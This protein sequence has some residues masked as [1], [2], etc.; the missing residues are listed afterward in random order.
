MTKA[1]LRRLR[2]VSDLNAEVFARGVVRYRGWIAIV[3]ALAAMV[4]VPLAGHLE[5]LLEVTAKFDQSESA[6]VTQTL[7][8]RFGSPFAHTAVLVASEIPDPRTP[9]GASVLG[10]IVKTVAQVPG[11][12]GTVS[13]LD[14]R[15]SFFVADDG[16][17]TFIVAGFDSGEESVGTVILRLR[18]ATLA[19]A[20]DLHNEYPGAQLNWSGEAALN[21]DIRSAS[22]AEAQAAELRALPLTLGVLVLA[23]GTLAAAGIP[24]ISGVLAIPLALGMAALMAGHWSMSALLVNVVTMIGLA[25]SIDY[26]LLTVSRFREGLADGYSPEQAARQAARYAGHTAVL[27]GLAVAIGFSALLVVP[28]NELRSVAVGGLLA[29][30]TAVLLAATLLPGVLAWLGSRI[31]FGRLWRNPARYAPSRRWARWGRWVADHPWRVLVLAGLPVLML[32]I[33]AHRLK[34]ELPRGDWLPSTTESALAI[35]DLQAMGRGGVVDTVRLVLFMPA[36]ASVLDRQGWDALG[37]LSRRLADDPRIDRVQ[38]LATLPGSEMLGPNLVHRLPELLHR[39]LLSPDRRATLV[40]AIP[41]ATLESFEVSHLVRELKSSTADELTGL[42]GARVLVGGTPAFQV[43]YEDAV[44]GHFP[45][46]VGLVLI[47]TFFA[48][49]VG[50][51]SILVPIKAIV[52]NLLSVAAGFGALVLVFQDG[53]GAELLGLSGPTGAVY[54]II[55][56]LVFCAVFG[57]S[58]DYEVFLVARVAE[59]RRSGMDESS[60][61]AEGLARTGGLITS[62]AAVMIAVFSAFMFGGFLLIKML[63]FALAVTVLIDATLVRVAIGPALFRLAGRWNWWPGNP[64]K[65]GPAAA[66]S[67]ENHDS[68]RK[69]ALSS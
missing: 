17:G 11:V 35:H 33:Q 4:L 52:L 36:G 61:L 49:V 1:L 7:T 31:E 39:S 44:V 16:N 22:L 53:Y 21:F 69:P 54:P 30:V 3:W 48:L 12:I 63:G 55:P 46:V 20:T 40:E 15:D 58:M 19:L 65:A 14:Y 25:L 24:L 41:M 38:S 67:L 37:R 56:A 23:F 5:E 8:E 60:A 6:L 57:L 59:A 62:A 34:L 42:P 13:H 43:E 51:R 50:F 45:A 9:K 10:R 66:V 29:T 32:G 64:I 18:E 47:G 68:Y 2:F 27:S 28:V 26:A